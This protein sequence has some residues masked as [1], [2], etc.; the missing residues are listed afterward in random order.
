MPVHCCYKCFKFGTFKGELGYLVNY[1]FQTQECSL[2]VYRDESFS[3]KEQ[4]KRAAG[5]CKNAAVWFHSR[6]LFIWWIFDRGCRSLTKHVF[7]SSK[8]QRLRP[9]FLPSQ[10]WSLWNLDICWNFLCNCSD[11]F[12]RLYVRLSVFIILRNLFCHNLH[13][14]PRSQHHSHHHPCYLQLIS[15]ICIASGEHNHLI[16]W[17]QDDQHRFP[18]GVSRLNC[19]TTSTHTKHY[20]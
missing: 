13:P 18:N 11:L 20:R 10:E 14:L 8:F 5:N 17:V 6:L 16:E 7:S 19:W 12:N 9:P 3:R 4:C 15:R 2:K 1:A